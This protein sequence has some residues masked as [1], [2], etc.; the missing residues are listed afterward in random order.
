MPQFTV[1]PLSAPGELDVMVAASIQSPGLMKLMS[2]GEREYNWDIKQAPGV[3]G[4]VMTYRGWKGGGDIVCRFEFFES[5]DGAGY[6][7]GKPAQVQQFYTQWVPLFAID[8]RKIRPQPVQVYHPVLFANDITAVVC[9][10]IGP[11]QT[12]GNMRWWVDMTFLE[13]RPPRLIPVS[14]PQ[15][16]T[17]ALGT[18]TPQ[19]RI[20]QQIE[21]ERV[22]AARPL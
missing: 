12:D 15:G 19:N 8:A 5:R 20:Q 13:Y 21:A 7:D 9:K 3:Q 11:L 22:L 17:A 10:K 18:P 4:Y 1:D 6:V 14:T 2:G 16:A